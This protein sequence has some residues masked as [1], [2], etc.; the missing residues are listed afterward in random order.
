[1]NFFA[2]AIL[3]VVP[4]L[5]VARKH[6]S[7][8]EWH[9][10]LTVLIVAELGNI[11]FGCKICVRETKFFLTSGKKEIVSEQQNMFP[12]HM[13]PARLSWETFASSTMFP[14][15]CFLV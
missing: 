5:A 9:W 2:A 6:F 15:Q 14:Q 1:L 8:S 10:K 11:C 12:Q 4:T 13:F 3:I 7:M